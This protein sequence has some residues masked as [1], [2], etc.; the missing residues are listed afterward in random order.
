MTEVKTNKYQT[1]EQ[2]EDVKDINIILSMSMDKGRETLIASWQIFYI[3]INFRSCNNLMKLA[4]H[5]GFMFQL[6]DDLDDIDIDIREK[7]VTL[8]S[9]P[10]LY[11]L[12]DIDEYMK[13]NV[14][15]LINYVM[16]INDE[17]KKI[18][19]EYVDENKK[20]QYAFAYLVYLNY[21]VAKNIML[22]KMFAEYE[23]LFP[24]KYDEIVEI[25]K[26]KQ[27]LALKYG[28]ISQINK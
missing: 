2:K 25:Y 9:Y 20:Q 14:L 8:F 19:S 4:S 11:E 12:E 13:T 7:N 18:D 3:N 22:K 27:L 26:Q 21:C 15:K 6:L 17:F 16:N 23:H 10:Y 24:I 1:F 5:M 28:I